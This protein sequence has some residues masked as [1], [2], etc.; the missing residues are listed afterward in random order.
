[1]R[2]CGKPIR[3][4]RNRKQNSSVE[5]CNRA[6]LWLSPLRKDGRV[7]VSIPKSLLL[8]RTDTARSAV[9]APMMVCIGPV[10]MK[11]GRPFM[12]CLSVLTNK[13]MF[14]GEV[15][16]GVANSVM[17][18]NQSLW[19]EKH[20]SW[21]ALNEL[22]HFAPQLHRNCSWSSCKET[23]RASSCPPLTISM[24]SRWHW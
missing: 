12:N 3:F 11:R 2:H 17:V 19:M 1:M 16:L 6:T 14:S 18:C 20:T 9:S 4:N 7:S 5:I 21:R 23:R 13:E 15:F 10:Y 24:K 8:R 22:R